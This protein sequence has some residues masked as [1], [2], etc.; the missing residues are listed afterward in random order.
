MPLTLLTFMDMDDIQN[1]ASKIYKQS[2]KQRVTELY[3]KNNYLMLSCD[4]KEL[5]MGL[6]LCLTCVQFK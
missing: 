1:F 5:F 4:N 2:L 3:F 6:H